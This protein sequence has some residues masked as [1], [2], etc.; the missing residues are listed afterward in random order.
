MNTHPTGTV[1]FLFTDIEGST[2]RWERHAAWMAAAHAR[3]EAILRD[4]IAAHGGWAYKQIGDAFQAAFQTAPAALAASVAAQQA[5]AA[6]PWGE[7]GPLRV[8]MALHSGAAEERADDYVGPLLNRVARLMAAGHGGQ[9]LLTT[10]T[11]ELVRDHLPAGVELRDLGE[12]RLKD[13]I[14]PERVWQVVADVL[15]AEFP[16]LKTLDARPNNLPAQP[17]AFIGREAQVA[18]VKAQLR[19]PDVRLLTLT[20]P[21]GTGKTRLALQVAADLLDDFPDGVWFV[22]LAPIQDSALVLSTIAATV[23]VKEAGSVPLEQALLA[24]LRSKR[25]LLLLDNCEQ[26]VSAAPRIGALLAGIAGL[27]VLATSRAPLGLYGEHAALVPPLGLPPAASQPGWPALGPLAATLSQYEAVRLFIERACAVKP[28]FA[29]TNENAPA[30]AEICARL[31]GLPLAIELAAARVRVLS[32]DALLARLGSRLRLLNGGS[33]DRPARHQTLRAA[34]DW[35]YNLLAADEQQFFRRLAVFQGG[36]TLAAA[37][38]I[39]YRAG[40]PAGDGLEALA[41]LFDKSLIQ[42]QEGNDGEP[43]FGMLQTI[44]EFA[45]EM[46]ATSGEEATQEQAHAEYFAHIAER[47]EPELRGPWTGGA[48][49]ELGQERDNMRAALAWCVRTGGGLGLGLRLALGLEHFWAMRGYYA[50]GRDWLEQLLEAETA[51]PALLRARALSAAGTLAW[52]CGD[53]E[54]AGQFHRHGLAGYAEAGDKRGVALSLSN[55]GMLLVEQGAC[56]YAEARTLIEQA[57]ALQRELGDSSGMAGTLSNLGHLLQLQGDPAAARALYEQALAL[58]Q[59]LGNRAGVAI[60]LGNLGIARYG[61]GN[62]RAAYGCF[63][64]SL[65]LA[66]ELR[67]TYVMVFCVAELGAVMVG[68]PQPRIVQRGARL[69]GAAAALLRVMGGALEPQDRLVYEQGVATARAALDAPTWEAACSAG[70]AMSL[71]DAVAYAL[72]EGP[73]DG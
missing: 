8:R 67:A 42:Q 46:L 16:L 41:A 6:E 15:P 28:E 45:R 17:N 27:R 59:A 35:S 58:Q 51:A 48:L 57:L 44:H 3:H 22:N 20:G 53:Y 31:D 10:A 64:E 2:E 54:R 52:L 38:A 55:L 43:R 7:P 36:W 68:W 47:A 33:I 73:P 24:A 50:E 66:R 30:V 56:E 13:L 34:I 26:V 71:D 72:A 40:G 63:Q 62:Y 25:L 70:E 21:G 61:E 12:Q 32:P 5:L 60:A 4:A 49:E 69:L 1:T 39:C 14:R 23:G 18:A 65:A 11:S 29:V 19:R 9:I 37:E